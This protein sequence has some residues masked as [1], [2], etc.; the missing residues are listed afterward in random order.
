MSEIGVEE[1]ERCRELVALHLQRIKDRLAVLNARYARE[2]K[3]TQDQYALI[4]ARL[5]KYRA[6]D[7]EQ[8]RKHH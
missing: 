1:L 5:S 4:S 2:I 8:V 6:P 3:R 7:M